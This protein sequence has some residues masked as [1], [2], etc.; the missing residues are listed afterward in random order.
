MIVARRKLE[1]KLER[2]RMRGAGRDT[3]R[4]GRRGGA[5]AAILLALLLLVLA[6]PVAGGDAMPGPQPPGGG[7]RPAPPPPGPAVGGLAFAAG[8]RLY[9]AE[10]RADRVAI[11]GA[12]NET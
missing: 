1:E 9:A 5:A 11:L 7:G 8:G 2:G 3:T 12:A 4:S 6:A 10:P